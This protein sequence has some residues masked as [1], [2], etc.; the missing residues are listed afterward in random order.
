MHITEASDIYFVIKL[1][2]Y[3]DILCEKLLNGVPA[4]SPSRWLFV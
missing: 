2:R 1:D 4:S 3:E